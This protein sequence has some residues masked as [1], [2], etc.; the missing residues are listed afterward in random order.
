M[1]QGKGRSPTLRKKT[2]LLRVWK[3]VFILTVEYGQI[4]QLQMK[5][6]GSF[7]RIVYSKG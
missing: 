3:K 7:W 4:I 2:V 1:A 6:Y 5:S